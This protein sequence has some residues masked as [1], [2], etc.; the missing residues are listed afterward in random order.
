MGRHKPEMKRLHR[1]KMQKR[2][3]KE[4]TAKRTGRKKP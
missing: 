3:A 4:S 2:K 1:R